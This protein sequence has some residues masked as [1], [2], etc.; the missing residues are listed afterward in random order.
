M[1]KIEI[2][3]EVAG[4]KVG[5]IK[6]VPV[7]IANTMIEKGLAKEVK[8]VKSEKVETKKVIKE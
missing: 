1:K 7:K 4:M 3:Q 5:T 6:N 2:T 8:A